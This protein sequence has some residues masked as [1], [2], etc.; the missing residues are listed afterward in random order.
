MRIFVTGAA[1]SGESRRSIVALPNRPGLA[2]T[3]ILIGT[4]AQN[5]QE[6]VYPQKLL[7]AP[8]Q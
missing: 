3:S 4:I 7:D 2:S 1:A 5:L 6:A 8:R